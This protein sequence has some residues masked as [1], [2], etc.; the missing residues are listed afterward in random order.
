MVTTPIAAPRFCLSSSAIVRS[1]PPSGSPGSQ[2]ILPVSVLC[3][4]AQAV[5]VE[6][7]SAPGCGPPAARQV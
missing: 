6:A 1:A 4:V 5:A 7:E 2:A 3:P